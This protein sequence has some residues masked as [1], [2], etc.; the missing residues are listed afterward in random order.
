MDARVNCMACLAHRY[1]DD[2]E[3]GV[4]IDGDIIHA[5]WLA[6]PVHR[7]LRTACDTFMKGDTVAYNERSV[8]ARPGTRKVP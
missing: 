4:G 8:M 2:M 3:P 5:L 6:P 7:H 1:P